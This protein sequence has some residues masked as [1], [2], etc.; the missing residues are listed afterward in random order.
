MRKSLV[1]M[2]LAAATWGKAQAAGPP[3]HAPGAEPAA[4][5]PAADPVLELPVALREALVAEMAGLRQSIAALAA[6]LATGEW[7]QA[8]ENARQVRD[9]YIMKQKLSDAELET[10]MRLLPAQFVALD[11]RF[12]RHAES[13]AHAAEAHDGDL[14]LYYFGKMLEGCQQCHSL[15]ATHTL[16]G[17][18]APRPDAHRH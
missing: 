18:E 6:Q 16:G 12:H 3:P 9:A 4:H 7:A 15:Y 8:A 1:L 5:M 14:T 10:L 17:F 2:V 11:G 13:L